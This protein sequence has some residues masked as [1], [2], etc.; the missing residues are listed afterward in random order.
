M[1]LPLFAGL[2]GL[3]PTN[4]LAAALITSALV[5]ATQTTWAGAST[6]SDKAQAKK[7]LLT[8]SDMPAGW[9]TEKNSAN[10][11]SGTFPGAKQLAGCIGVPSK[12]IN[13][14]PPEVDSPYFATKS[15]SLEVQDTVSIF[16]SA[17]VARTSLAAMANPKTP[18][19]M[20]ALMNG[21]FKSNIAASAGNGAKV[22][23]I[24]VSRIDPA[25]FGR[26]TTGLALSLPVTD[27]GV[28]ITAVIQ[29]VFY[30]KGKFGQQI[31][32]NSYGPPFPAA[33][34]KSLTATAINRL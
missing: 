18:S 4:V 15:G 10:N 34:A 11:G 12:L 30:V 1:P 5:A 23:T 8:L 2:R 22:G 28:S 9:K 7:Y 21:A 27:Q 13:A 32:F 3:R 20:A 25:E 17:K 16:S 14:N 26:G 6:S 33:T 31:T 29:A 24:T 19:C